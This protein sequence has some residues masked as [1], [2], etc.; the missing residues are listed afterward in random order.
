VAAET[1]DPAARFGSLN[2]RPAVEA[3]GA[4]PDWAGILRAE[5]YIESRELPADEVRFAVREV[6][7]SALRL[8]RAALGLGPVT[9]R[10]YGTVDGEDRRTKRLGSEHYTPWLAEG[11]RRGF[12][13]KARPR[14]IWIRTSASTREIFETVCHEARHAWQAQTDPPAWR[15]P[16]NSA[17]YEADAHAYAAECLRWFDATTGRG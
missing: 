10:W 1:F 13:S 15:D 2:G 5:G 8:A 3:L 6:G 11:S 17:E 16:A 9:L 12:V 4:H 7:Q 14:E